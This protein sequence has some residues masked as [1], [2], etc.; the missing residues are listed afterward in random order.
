MKK[1]ELTRLIREEIQNV[2]T[3]A[4]EKEFSVATLTWDML[5]PY[6][7][8][9]G[10][11]ISLPITISS[12]SI[13]KNED[14]FNLWKERFLRLYGDAILIEPGNNVMNQYFIVKPG[15]SLKWDKSAKSEASGIKA[16]YTNKRYTGD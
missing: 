4:L 5:T 14:Q 3:E 12:S 13:L 11:E 1:S 6:K 7:S 10:K 8:K 9:I 16:D 15:S 2:L